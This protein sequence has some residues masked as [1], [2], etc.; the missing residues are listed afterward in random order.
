VGSYQDKDGD[1]KVAWYPDDKNPNEKPPKGQ[2]PASIESRDGDKPTEVSSPQNSSITFPMD[3]K[4]YASISSLGEATAEFQNEFLT[5]FGGKAPKELTTAFAQ[6]LRNLQASRSNKRVGKNE[7]IVIQGVSPQE[8]KDILN[9]YLKNYATQQITLANTGDAKA[10]ATL[11]RGNFGLT[12]TTLKNAYADNGLPINFQNL[13]KVATE[14]TLNPDTLKAN[15]NL[16]NMQAKT[17]FPALADKID[18]GYTVKQLLTPY[19]NARANI[20][21]EDPDTIDVKNLSDVAKDP[22]SLMNLYDYEISLR[23]DPKW[24]YTKNAQDSIS[25]VARSIASTFGLMG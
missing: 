6:E 13:S 25:N 16:I 8:R 10:Q 4:P 7:D 17:Y 20:L 19:I 21:E 11:Q 2:D 15:I 12:L 18:K 22:K 14:S 23:K 3:S 9:K 5:V 1:D 24:R